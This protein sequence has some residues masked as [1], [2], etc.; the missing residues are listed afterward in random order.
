MPA[1]SH[2]PNDSTATI[3]IGGGLAG[4]A[5]AAFLA[6]AGRPVT[7]LE[8]APTLGGRAATADRA[9][10]VRWN[11]GPHALYRT[12]EAMAVLDALGVSPAGA[13]PPTAGAAA[14]ARGRLHRLPAGPWSLMTTT[15]L[16]L[17]GKLAVGRLL[18]AL[19][20]LDPATLAGR[21]VADWIDGTLADPR[22]R[23]LLA[24]LVRL[25]TYDA[26]PGRQDAGAAV[27]QL[28]RAFAGNVLYLDDGWASLVDALADAARSAGAEL[29]AG[30]AVREVVL[31]DRDGRAAVTGV[32]TADGRLL[33]AG[34]VVLAGTSAMAAA[35]VE[36][37]GPAGVVHH[38]AAGA[39]PSRVACLDL[40]L[41]SPLPGPS[42]VLGTDRPLYLSNH[43]ASARLG[44]DG[45]AVVHAAKYVGD[46]AGSRPEEDERE[47]EELLD[48]AHPG[49]RAKLVDRRFLPR[50]A[51]STAAVSAA[52]GG[53]AGR[54]GPVVPGID[55]LLVAGDWVGARGQL[56]DA[57]LASGR[58]AAEAILAGVEA[59]RV[60]DPPAALV[61]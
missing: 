16:G 43:S 56:A 52:D 40:A 32:R 15:L 3:V 9:D 50:L 60:A 38:W 10:G 51:A 46:G 25:T 42:F 14:H 6:R 47:L 8:R 53:L 21:S 57:S 39:R 29:V 17:R 33:G 36:A 48:L 35:L 27:A 31:A 49:W 4:L 23:E 30:V 28:Q 1:P 5:A 54:P 55:G 22:A 61:A 12:G 19:P 7:L 45:V 34:D 13:L 44:P 18:G 11:L 59:P 20:R 58:S 41:R 37:D 24:G 26:D 2:V